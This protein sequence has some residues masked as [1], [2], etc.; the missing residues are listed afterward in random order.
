MGDDPRKWTF[1]DFKRCTDGHFRCAG[2]QL[3][4][5]RSGFSDFAA[6]NSDEDLV[7]TFSEATDTIA[8]AF[9]ARGAF[10]ARTGSLRG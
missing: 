8:G 2:S 3:R 5:R 6:L 9:K 1:G 7:K 10:L 4:L